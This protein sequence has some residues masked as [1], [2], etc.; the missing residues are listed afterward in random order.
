MWDRYGIGQWES[1]SVVVVNEMQKVGNDL[2]NLC[3]FQSLFVVIHIEVCNFSR[4][5]L[6][7]RKQSLIWR[8]MS[9]DAV[10]LADNM[11]VLV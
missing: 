7:K 1:Q 5:V 11:E 3:F 10:K 9:V 6:R 4:Q 2:H 8:L